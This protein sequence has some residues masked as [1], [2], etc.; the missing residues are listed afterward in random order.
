MYFIDKLIMVALQQL[1]LLMDCIMIISNVSFLYW[2]HDWWFPRMHIIRSER[3]F[4]QDGNTFVCNRAT[5]TR[6]GALQCQHPFYKYKHINKCCHYYK[7]HAWLWEEKPPARNEL[8]DGDQ[9]LC[10][11]VS[12]ET[13]H[14][15]LLLMTS[16]KDNNNINRKLT[17][18][19]QQIELNWIQESI[20]PAPPQKWGGLG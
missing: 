8:A 4:S 11:I 13:V 19:Q 10:S 14:H 16:I 5:H 15:M 3:C 7:C 20:T 18:T 2:Q 6:G 17:T 1:L 9:L 12:W